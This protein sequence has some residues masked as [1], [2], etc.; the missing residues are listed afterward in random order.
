MAT[1]WLRTRVRRICPPFRDPAPSQLQFP[2]AGTPWV[3]S[4]GRRVGQKRCFHERQ[5]PPPS[6]YCCLVRSA[7]VPRS[8]TVSGRLRRQPSHRL[9]SKRSRALAQATRHQLLRASWASG[10]RPWDGFCLEWPTLTLRSLSP[11]HPPV[12][13]RKVA[14]LVDA[15]LCRRAWRRNGRPVLIARQGLSGPGV[16]AALCAPPRLEMIAGPPCA[17]AL[18]TSLSKSST[19]WR[20]HVRRRSAVPSRTKESA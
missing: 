19:S 3:C 10:V 4:A 17:C 12:Q 18:G 7:F 6:R 13:S 15:A 8:M 5:R 20:K 14:A 11:R 9:L 2:F 1:A 16:A